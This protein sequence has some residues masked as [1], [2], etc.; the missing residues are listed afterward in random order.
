[1]TEYI[2]Y[3][4]LP[5]FPQ[6]IINSIPRDFSLYERKTDSRLA[7]AYMWTDS[8]NEQVN[9]WC[10]SNIC[11]DMYFAFQIITGDLAMHKDKDTKIK[12]NY[13]VQTG[14]DKVLTEFF[15]DD[16]LTKVASYNIDANRW[17]IFKADSYHSVTNIIPGQVRFSIT[18]RI[19]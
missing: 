19:F 2:R 18:G 8:F 7:A 17:H 15:D 6:Q 14:G 3:L 11:S 16:Q 4:N 10:Q 9:R 12:I 1:M 5:S 13:L